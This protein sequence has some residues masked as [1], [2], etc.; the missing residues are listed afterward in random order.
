MSSGIL[1]STHPVASFPNFLALLLR[2]RGLRLLFQSFRVSVVVL[3]DPRIRVIV[4]HEVEHVLSEDISGEGAEEEKGGNFS[5]G[6]RLRLLCL[7]G[8][9]GSGSGKSL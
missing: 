8:E 3:H 7:G 6:S 9:S 1:V 5:V 4:I 2:L